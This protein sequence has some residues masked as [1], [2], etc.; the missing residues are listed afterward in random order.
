MSKV[1]SIPDEHL[2]KNANHVEEIHILVDTIH[3]MVSYVRSVI[4]AFVDRPPTIRNNRNGQSGSGVGGEGR[5]R[6]GTQNSSNNI[7][8]DDTS[9][10]TNVSPLGDDDQEDADE[11]VFILN[12]MV[13]DLDQLANLLAAQRLKSIQRYFRFI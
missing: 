8:L 5:G 9:V 2:M 7:W 6:S 11:D 4:P 10:H 1:N 12:P 13:D 3:A